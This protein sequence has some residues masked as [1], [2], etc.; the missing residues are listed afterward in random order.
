MKMS[1]A[2]EGIFLKYADDEI[3]LAEFVVGVKKLKDW[4]RR[5]SK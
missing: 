3:N 4:Y 1:E 5:N 2:L